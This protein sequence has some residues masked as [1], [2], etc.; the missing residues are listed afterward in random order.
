MADPVS[1]PDDESPE[2]P[3]LRD[4]WP[5]YEKNRGY[6][7]PPPFRL[8]DIHPPDPPDSDIRVFRTFMAVSALV[9]AGLFLWSLFR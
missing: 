2:E 4:Y 3:D 9:M 6:A 1:P 5:W 8:R 7:S